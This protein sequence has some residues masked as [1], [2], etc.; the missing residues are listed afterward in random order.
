MSDEICIH[1]G[2]EMMTS[3][4]LIAASDAH[5]LSSTTDNEWRL[6]SPTDPSAQEG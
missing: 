6:F 3:N 5:I 4:M 1:S 2:Y